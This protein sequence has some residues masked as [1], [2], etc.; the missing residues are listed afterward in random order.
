MISVPK[1]RENLDRICVGTAG[2]HVAGDDAGRSLYPCRRDWRRPSVAPA[3]RFP[4]AS[5][6]GGSAPSSRARAGGRRDRWK[7][8]M[9]RCRTAGGRARG[10]VAHPFIFQFRKGD[11]ADGSFLAGLNREEFRFGKFDGDA[12]AAGLI[13]GHEHRLRGKVLAQTQG[14]RIAARPGAVDNLPIADDAVGRSTDGELLPASFVS[15][16][17][18]R[19]AAS[20]AATKAARLVWRRIFP[21]FCPAWKI[22]ELVAGRFQRVVDPLCFVTG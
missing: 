18:L 1:A 11:R 10:D 20:A 5:R 12:H 2:Q 22:R 6:P 3:R 21:C 4:R 16:P 15:S 13:Q 7:R 17:S 19:L 14:A 8:S 9:C